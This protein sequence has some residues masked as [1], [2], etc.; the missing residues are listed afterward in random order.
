MS[1][2]H[3]PEMTAGRLSREEEAAWVE[4]EGGCG[5]RTSIG[6]WS[7]LVCVF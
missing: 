1:G 7:E 4:M 5:E 2:R 6:S 3:G